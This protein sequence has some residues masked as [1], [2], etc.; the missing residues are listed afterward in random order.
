MLQVL[1][2]VQTSDGSARKIDET[3]YE[4]KHVLR[5]AHEINLN[6]NASIRAKQR[7]NEGTFVMHTSDASVSKIDQRKAETNQELL[8]GNA[9]A[10][11]PGSHLQF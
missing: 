5:K 1:H 10:L 3:K 4:T 2:L 9:S 7:E 8:R 6:T 11:K